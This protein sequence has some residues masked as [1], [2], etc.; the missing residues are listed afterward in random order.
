MSSQDVTHRDAP[1]ARGL[2][3]LV[4]LLALLAAGCSSAPLPDTAPPTAAR[5][6]PR[7]G[8]WVEVWADEFEGETLDR[9]SW[10]VEVMPDPLNE[11][12]QYYPDRAD[13]DPG[14]NVWVE[15]GLLVIEA[16]REDYRHRHHTSAQVQTQGKR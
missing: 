8:G 2:P 4:A 11:E 13:D 16:Q 5:E 9:E 7:T 3:V 1:P 12:L 10:N 15:D 6:A 14:S